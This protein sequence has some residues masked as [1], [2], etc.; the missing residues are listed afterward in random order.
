M[1]MKGIY[2]AASGA[3]AQ[4]QKLDTIAN[5]IANV[6]TPSF[7]KDQQVFKEYLSANEKQPDVLQVPRVP[8]SIDS[9]YDMQ[10]GDISYVD[11][12]GSFTDY[13]QGSLKL[14]NNPLDVAIDGKGFFEVGTPQ[15]VRLTRNGSF[16]IDNSGQ[17]V[18]KDGHVV[19]K[20]SEPGTDPVE[21]VIRIENFQSNNPGGNKLTISDGGEIFLGSAKLGNISLVDVT[22]KDSLQKQGATLYSFKP[23]FKPEITNVEKPSL[24]TGFVEMSNVNVVQ[25]M[26]D[27]ITT[28]RMFESIQKAI[29]TYDSMNEKMANQVGA[30]K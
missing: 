6:T 13:S 12:V 21:R 8:A 11:N 2:A 10:G 15:G 24:K 3:I 1:S 25:E 28:T 19:L 5:N 4:S 23:N 27:M 7:K 14:T 29:Q 16:K 26:T 17:L 30:L 20:S 9:F 18:T 22:Q